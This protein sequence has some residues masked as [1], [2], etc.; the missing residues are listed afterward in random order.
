MLG[1][2]DDDSGPTEGDSA[3]HYD[4]GRGGRKGWLGKQQA[5]HGDTGSLEGQQQRRW[6]MSDKQSLGQRWVAYRPTKGLL[7]W[8][9]AAGA[10]A[11]MVV[12][13]NWGGWTTGGTARSMAENAAA[14]ARDQLVAA[15][16]VDRFQAG[17]DAHAQL[18]ALKALG[19]YERGSFV[20]KGG[21]ATMPDK[22]VPTGTATRLCADKLV[23]L[24]APVAS[25]A[26]VQ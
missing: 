22:I 7:V 1:Q 10:I 2:F 18:G 21:W 25:A 13:F 8:S 19:A 3:S 14:S 24:V 9:C 15:V 16:C 20:E 11:V 12:G 5:R 17:N 6:I 23:A 4:G 26:A